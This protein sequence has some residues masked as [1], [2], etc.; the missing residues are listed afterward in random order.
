MIA[1]PEPRDK[2]GRSDRFCVVF[3]LVAMAVLVNVVLGLGY[4]H[5]AFREWRG[6]IGIL[7]LLAIPGGVALVPVSFFV[8]VG[9]LLKRRKPGRVCLMTAF[10]SI[11]LGGAMIGVPAMAPDFVW[12]LWALVFMFSYNL[13]LALFVGAEILGRLGQ[14]T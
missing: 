3:H 6:G 13:V 1:L 4:L 11:S 10:S 5:E 8:S 7:A 12:V 14:K 9:P 2:P